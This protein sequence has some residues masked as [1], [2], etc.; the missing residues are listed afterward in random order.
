MVTMPSR[1]S[2][3]WD[4]IAAETI[5]R[6]RT[7]SLRARAGSAIGPPRTGRAGEIRGAG[8]DRDGVRPTS[9]CQSSVSLS[10][11]RC[12]DSSVTSGRSA[13]NRSHASRT[14]VTC[15][16]SPATVATPTM[17]RRCRSWSPTSAAATADR[18]R[19]S[20]TIGRTTARLPLSEW[21]SPSSR[22]P[23]SGPGEM[24]SAPPPPVGP[25]SGARDLAHLEGL[26]HVVDLDVVERP[27]ADT[28][29]VTLANLGRVV[30]EPAE[31]LHR[32]VVGDHGPVTH[33]PRLRVADDRAA[34]DERTGDVADPRH[35]EDLADLRRTELHLLVDG[36]E[37]A[38]EGGLDLVDGLVDD[39]V[40]PDVHT[41][42]VGQLGGLTLGPDVE[43][44]DDDVV[45]QRQVDVALGDP[46]DA[47]VDDP[48]RDVVAHL[49]LHQRLFERLDGARVVALDDQVELTGLLERRV[50]VLQADPL[51]HGGVLRVA[52]PG[53]AAVGDLPGD[54]VL[55]D[56]EEGVTGARHGGQADDLDRTGRQGL[57]ELVAVLVEQRP[58]ATVGVAGHDR[59]ALAQRAALDQHRGD[60]APALVQLALDDHT[61]RVLADVRTQVQGGVGGQQDRR[62]Q[63]VETLTRGGR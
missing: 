29:L 21:T 60:G 49:D 2:L 34:A 61:L 19:S 59:V 31:G 58:D 1:G 35:P 63:V 20:A 15:P 53:L 9:R 14:S 7:A 26:D 40:V 13:S 56:D 46:A 37:H 55:L 42:A 24:L 50:Q 62:E 30:L 38:L 43:A 6:M 45:G 48:Q 39:R 47:A 57:L 10:S 44:Q 3:I 12:V 51:A 32:Q 25:V 33:E 36:L 23:L 27:Q 28:A 4:S 17:A 16:T 41:L 18:R 8:A 5:C 54:P 22:S 52:D 11:C